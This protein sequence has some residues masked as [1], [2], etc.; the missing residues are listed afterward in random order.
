LHS[1]RPDFL[2]Q[3]RF[4]PKRL[5]QRPG[6]RD[7]RSRGKL[8]HARH[9]SDHRKFDEAEPERKRYLHLGRQ[10]ANG[11]QGGDKMPDSRQGVR[12]LD[13]QNKPDKM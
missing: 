13:K 7:W 10:H 1:H 11:D 5:T 6:F 3:S 2:R 9:L 8:R 4:C 12:P